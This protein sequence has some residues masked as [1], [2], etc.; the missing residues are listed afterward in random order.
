MT[1]KRFIKIQTKGELQLINLD[2]VNYV[3]ISEGNITFR[4]SKEDSLMFTVEQLG[5]E[6]FKKLK[7][8]LTNVNALRYVT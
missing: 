3:K 6:E 1:G 2:H 8:N 7:D 4:F 5:K